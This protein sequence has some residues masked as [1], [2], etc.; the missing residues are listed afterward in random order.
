MNRKNKLLS[1]LLAL[2]MLCSL[3][4]PALAAN[5]ILL[6]APA[7]SAGN[8]LVIAPNPSATPLAGKTVILHTND[9]HGAVDSYA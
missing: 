4:A 5:D 7:P 8:E 1:L 9:T 2:V 6:I 3:T